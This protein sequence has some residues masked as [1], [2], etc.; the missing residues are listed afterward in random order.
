M[1]VMK[2][3]GTSLHDQPAIGRVV[4]IVQ[5]A[6]SK[7]PVVVV[8]AMGKTTRRLLEAALTSSSGDRAAALGDLEAIRRYHDALAEQ[9]VPEWAGTG[10][11]VRIDAYFEELRRLLDGLSILGECSPRSQD[12]VLSYGELISSS[13]IHEAFMR[14]NLAS[15]W[16]DSRKCI[17][18]DECYT[19]ASPL[20]D[21]TE[22]AI[23]KMVQPVL[24]KNQVPLLQG[25]I[26]SSKKGA[27]TTL[28]FEGSDFSA[29]LIGSALD[30]SEIQIWKDVPGVMTA[31]PELL[32]GARTVK[33]VTFEE[34]G[35]LTFFGAKVLHPKSI[36][37]ARKRNIPVRVCNSKKPEAEASI[38][39]GVAPAG[40]NT[41]KSIAYKKPLALV[42]VQSKMILPAPAFYQNTMDAF[43]R[44]GVVPYAF[45]TSENT[46]TAASA[47]DHRLEA[48][49]EKCSGFAHVDVRKDK[50]AVT[51]IGENIC[52]DRTFPLSVLTILKDETVDLVSVGGSGTSMTL[53][54]GSDAVQRV[55]AS[56]HDAFFKEWDPEVFC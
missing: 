32:P 26:G 7:H 45:V 11:K 50:A 25:Y 53:V 27:T 8:S 18:T 37:P 14:N 13:I 19:E 48:V 15:V 52:S 4:R 24:L 46:I 17:L 44:Q 40:K 12:K 54:L 22:E 39:T 55:L 34:A 21:E 16:L 31:D 2:F 20:G 1:I 51:L 6:L 49:Q 43:T 10:G 28:G 29:A 33:R 3:G 42:R 38:I 30:V 56:L 36:E 41:V 23:R 5:N 47:V 35:R 9:V